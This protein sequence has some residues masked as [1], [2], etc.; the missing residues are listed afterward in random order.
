MNHYYNTAS[1]LIN[2]GRGSSSILPQSIRCSSGVNSLQDCSATDL[3]IGK[4]KKVAGADCKG[5]S[6]LKAQ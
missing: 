3:D 5:I 1:A 6:A 2:Y 4:C